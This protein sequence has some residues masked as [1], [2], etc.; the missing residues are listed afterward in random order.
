VLILRVTGLLLAGYGLAMVARS[1]AEEHPGM[2]R[3]PPLISSDGEN[4]IHLISVADCLANVRGSTNSSLPL[5]LTATVTLVD[6]EHGLVVLQDDS[7]AMAVNT[8]LA[9]LAVSP[10]QQVSIKGDGALPYI[11]AFPRYPYQPSS[12]LFLSSFEATPGRGTYYLARFRGYLTPPTTGQY[13]FWI[14]ADDAGEF[15]LST[16]ASPERIEKLA[17]NPVGNASRPHEWDHVSLQRSGPVTLQAGQKYYVEALHIQTYGSD[18]LSVAWEGPGIERSVIAGNYLSPWPASG[19]A[20]AQSSDDGTPVNGLLW[21]C[22]TNFTMRDFDAL[23]APGESDGIIRIEGLQWITTGA[24]QLPTP[25][26]SVGG[27]RRRCK[28]CRR[29]WG[30]DAD[31]NHGEGRGAGSPRFG[32]QKSLR[33]AT[34]ARPCPAPGSP[35]THA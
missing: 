24:G 22:W 34:L 35:G 10:G 19:S 4:E 20:T 25:L 17:T 13:M 2:A 8:S 32:P 9:D 11:S 16:N 7:A 27:A 23:R 18:N 1:A 3:N 6:R 12:H 15:Y 28:F 30:R 14:A 29:K 26:S 33:R 21:E 31:G 5:K